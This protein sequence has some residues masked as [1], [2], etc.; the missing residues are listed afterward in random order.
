LLV[1]LLEVIGVQVAI[2]AGP[3]EIADAEVALLRQHMRQQRIRGDVERHPEENI[4]TSLVEQAGQLA[5]RNVELEQAVTWR[6]R[7]PVDLA[8][9]PGAHDDAARVRVL[10]QLPHDLTDLVD[11]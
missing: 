5:V 11:R 7:H 4:A 8:D 2:T 9:V 10:L 1:R 3:D 6:Q